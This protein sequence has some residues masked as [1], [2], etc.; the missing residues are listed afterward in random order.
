MKKLLFVALL[1]LA[2]CL[3]VPATSHVTKVE[4]TS[5]VSIEVDGMMCHNCENLITRSISALPGVRFVVASHLDKRVTVDFDIDV[6]SLESIKNE[7][8]S[9]G[10]DVK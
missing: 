3:D 4:S 6:I 1:P 9:L 8:A 2:G 7:I 10:F 5:S